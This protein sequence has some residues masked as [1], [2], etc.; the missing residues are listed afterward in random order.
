M[1]AM[2]AVMEGLPAFKD[3]PP[4]SALSFRCSSVKCNEQLTASDTQPVRMV[5]SVP[6]RDCGLWKH[7]PRKLAQYQP[8]TCR[9]FLGTLKSRFPQEHGEVPGADT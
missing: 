5:L 1:V 3:G 6:S 9:C 2:G 4:R 8:H 7:L